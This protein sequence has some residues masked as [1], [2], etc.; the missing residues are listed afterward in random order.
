MSSDMFVLDS[1]AHLRR[2]PRGRYQ[3][4]LTAA[5]I[6]SWTCGYQVPEDAIPTCSRAGLRAGDPGPFVCVGPRVQRVEHGQLRVVD[7]PDGVVDGVGGVVL[8]PVRVRGRGL[9]VQ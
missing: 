1:R 6:A 8:S 3:C 9:G 7:P 5:T 2:R 4:G